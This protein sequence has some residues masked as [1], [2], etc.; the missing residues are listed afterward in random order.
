MGE[1]GQVLTQ[2]SEDNIKELVLSYH[3]GLGSN[4]G[5]QV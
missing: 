3:V 1:C 5:L 4:S 2:R